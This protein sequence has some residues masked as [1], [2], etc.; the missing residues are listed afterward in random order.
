MFIF[1]ISQHNF[2]KGSKFSGRSD[3]TFSFKGDLC[4]KT[5]LCH[6]AARDVQLMNFFI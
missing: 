5:I 3:M 2:R 6:K 1:R 4:Y